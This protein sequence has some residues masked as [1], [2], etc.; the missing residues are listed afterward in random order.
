MSEGEADRVI[1]AEELENKI[2]QNLSGVSYVKAIDVSDTCAGQK[3]EVE[4][5]CE[6]FRGKPLLQQHRLV[7][8]AIEEE[9]KKYIHALT[10][11]TKAP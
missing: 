6:E 4:I 9:R 3:F 8:K 7:H 2:K 1:T 11:K 10:L 5:I